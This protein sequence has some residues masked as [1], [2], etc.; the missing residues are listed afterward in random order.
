MPKVVAAGRKPEVF[1]CGVCHRAD[2][3]GGPESSSLF[4]LSADY[5]IRQTQEFRTGQRSG[6]ASRVPTDLMT[7]GAK[8]VTDQELAEAAA[9]F[10]A[11]K[12]RAN[13]TV[14]ETD[15]VPRTEVR[16]L[17]LTPI[18]GTEREPIGQRIIEVPEPL[19]DYI[20]RDSHVRFVAYIPKGSLEKGKALA[21]TGDPRLACATCH[22]EG[23][24][25]TDLAPS[26][27]GRSPTY[28]FRQLYDF[29]SGARN[30]ANS[31]LMKPIV[32][33]LSIDNMIALAAYAGS[34]TS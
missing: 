31:E 23:L 33:A 7:K 9:Y 2:G 13:L 12:P 14:L 25:G 5:I 10:A 30:G 19:E 18:A 4:G 22:G 6:S 28:L 21:T 15:T 27:A 8:A 16:E 11:I 20:S 1:A 26:V 3:P 17:F 29:K 34:L 32:E 24:R